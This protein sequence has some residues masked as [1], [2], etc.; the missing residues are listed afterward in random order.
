MF[1]IGLI[2]RLVEAVAALRVIA[3]EEIAGLE[4]CKEIH[5]LDAAITD[6]TGG[7]K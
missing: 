7:V 3:V 6:L 1:K 5:E 2:E 4:Q